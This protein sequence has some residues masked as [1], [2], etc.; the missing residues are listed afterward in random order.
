MHERLSFDKAILTGPPPV[1]DLLIKDTASVVKR[2]ALPSKQAAQDFLKANWMIYK[3][4]AENAADP[5]VLLA[6]PP[7]IDATG[8]KLDGRFVCRCQS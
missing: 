4:M 6:C 2:C 8:R 1:G 5:M 7:A 3:A